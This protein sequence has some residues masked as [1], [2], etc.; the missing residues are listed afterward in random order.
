MEFSPSPWPVGRN[1]IN[2]APQ[3]TPRNTQETY[4]EHPK[5]L[6]NAHPLTH[7][8]TSPDHVKSCLGPC[9]LFAECRRSANQ[10]RNRH[11]LRK[12]DVN[13]CVRPTPGN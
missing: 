12:T 2:A 3:S 1:T 4:T 5:H 8:Q 6:P 13:K 9:L 11:N 10:N 7:P